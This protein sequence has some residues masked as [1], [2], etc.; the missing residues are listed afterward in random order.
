[1]VNVDDANDQQWLR[2]RVIKIKKLCSKVIK[3]YSKCY[4]EI[5]R[6]PLPEQPLNEI[7]LSFDQHMERRYAKY[8]LTKE[9]EEQWEPSNKIVHNDELSNTNNKS[10]EHD[11]DKINIDTTSKDKDEDKDI[12][13]KFL[14]LGKK[15]DMKGVEESLLLGVRF[16]MR[17][18][19]QGKPLQKKQLQ[20]HCCV[21]KIRNLCLKVTKGYSKHYIEI[22]S[23]PP[24]KLCLNEIKLLFDWRLECRCAKYKLTKEEEEQL[25]LSYINSDD[26][27]LPNT[28]DKSKEHGSDEFNI[29][30]TSKGE[31]EDEDD[32]EEYLH[33]SEKVD[34]EGAEKLYWLG[35]RILGMKMERRELLEKEHCKMKK[36]S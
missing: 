29:Y 31:D 23:S 20:L 30:T 12:S 19:A 18:S 35:E 4:N 9:E 2:C 11:L 6:C 25:E 34:M 1:M 16:W 13:E 21:I 28:N 15:I 33:I 32:G 36:S 8:N 17:R 10:K 7:K 24:P 14:H 5:N 27:K 26:D 22:N 3:G